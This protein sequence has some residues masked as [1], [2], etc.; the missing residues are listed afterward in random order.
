MSAAAV[1]VGHSLQLS[2]VLVTAV[3]LILCFGLRVMATRY[4]WRLP[5]TKIVDQYDSNVAKGDSND[6]DNS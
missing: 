1:V 4:D 5:I 3:A 2:V 6:L